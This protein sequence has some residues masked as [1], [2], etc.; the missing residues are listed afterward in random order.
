MRATAEGAHRRD[1]EARIGTPDAL[2]SEEP[3]RA[4]RLPCLTVL[5]HAYADA[6]AEQL[7]GERDPCWAGAHDAHVDIEL[8]VRGQCPAVDDH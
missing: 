4:P 1:D 6:E 2:P 8:G 3:L 7:A 5:E